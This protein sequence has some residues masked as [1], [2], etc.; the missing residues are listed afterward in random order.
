MEIDMEK[1]K[2]IMIMVIKNSKENISME[3]NGTEKDILDVK[4]MI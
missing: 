2:N 3:K 4:K 1:G